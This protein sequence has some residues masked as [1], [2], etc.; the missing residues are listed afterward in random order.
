MNDLT[1][2]QNPLTAYF[3]SCHLTDVLHN[4]TMFIQHTCG[5]GS[6]T[7][8]LESSHSPQDISI[9]PINVQTSCSRLFLCDYWFSLD[10]I[11]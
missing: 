9:V 3:N 2:L 8:P 6:L 10:C 4:R 7:R 1:N 5:D 11:S